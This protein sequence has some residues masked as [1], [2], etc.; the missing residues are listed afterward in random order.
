MAGKANNAVAEEFDFWA[1]LYADD[2][3]TV[4][5]SRE[6]LIEG[7]ETL[8]QHFKL[9]GMLMHVGRDGGKSKTEAMFCPAGKQAE[10]QHNY[11]R[12]YT[13]W[14]SRGTYLRCS[15]PLSS[16]TTARTGA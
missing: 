3:A 14:T 10:L 12:D 16:C 11:A 15:S 5:E 1:S 8:Y 7:T 13:A 2:A 9:F 4:F 6:E